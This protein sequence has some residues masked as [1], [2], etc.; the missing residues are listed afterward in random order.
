MCKEVKLCNTAPK[1]NNL[2]T[3]EEGYDN[4]TERVS[5]YPNVFGLF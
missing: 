4:K 2:G 1:P 3:R 5:K